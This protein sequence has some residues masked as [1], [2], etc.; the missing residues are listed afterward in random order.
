MPDVLSGEKLKQLREFLVNG[1]EEY[2]LRKN[3]QRLEIRAENLWDSTGNKTE[4]FFSLLDLANRHWWCKLLAFCVLSEFYD[5]GLAGSLL[6]EYER[7]GLR[8]FRILDDHRVPEDDA[9]RCY[10]DAKP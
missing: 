8:L 1:L 7:A 2:E 5:N 3:L 9:V 10:Y 4:R 6:T